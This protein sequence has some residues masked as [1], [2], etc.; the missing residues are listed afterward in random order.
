MISLGQTANHF[1]GALGLLELTE[2]LLDVLD[3]EC[4]LLQLVL[5]NLVFPSRGR[6]GSYTCGACPSFRILMCTS[7]ACAHE[8]WSAASTG[9]ESEARSFFAPS[10]PPIEAVQGRTV[11]GVR[12][13]GKR[14]VLSLAGD[15]YLIL[16]LMIAGRLHWREPGVAIPKKRGQA[17]F[18]FPNGTLLLAEAGSTRRASLHVAQGEDSLR[19]H[20]RGGIEVLES[21]LMTFGVALRRENHTLKRALTDPRLF[22]GIGNAYSD[23][24]LHAARL[25]PLTLTRRLADPDIARL[26]TATIRTL[27]GWVARLRDEV[28][29]GFPEKVT[30]FPTR[31]GRARTVPG[32]L[33]RTAD[34]R[35]SG[36]STPATRPTTAP[37]VRPTARSSPTEPCRDC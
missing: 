10:S 5:P 2:V 13:V 36:S 4:P 26:H 7:S 22:S 8:L 37:P 17:A 11:G 31:H 30:A 24:I 18:D 25:S 29:D 12:R 3:F 27:T 23:E 21:D 33:S 14:I 19:Q 35:F 6:I 20:D 9:S 16:H 1:A 32:A 15:L 34:R 28:G